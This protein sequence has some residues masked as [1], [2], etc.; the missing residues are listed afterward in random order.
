MSS[1][2]LQAK[3]QERNNSGIRLSKHSYP[4][5][6]VMLLAVD[7]LV[8][9]TGEDFIDVK[10]VTVTSVLSFQSTGTDGTEFDAPKSDRFA[11]DCDATFG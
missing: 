8:R 3:N 2:F 6:M 1:R 7:L 4:E 9:H 5:I 11:A 10:S